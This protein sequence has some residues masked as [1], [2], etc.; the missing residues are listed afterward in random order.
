M[1][2]VQPSI[3]GWVLLNIWGQLKSWYISIYGH[4]ILNEWNFIWAIILIEFDFIL[5]QFHVIYEEF[6]L[7]YVIHPFLF[8]FFWDGWKYLLWLILQLEPLPP[9]H[10]HSLYVGRYHSAYK[11]SG[12]FI[13]LM[14][15]IYMSAFSVDSLG[16]FYM[17][18]TFPLICLLSCLWFSNSSY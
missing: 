18:C 3:Q 1:K 5:V 11:D 16:T 17:S 14:D 13:L 4:T 8:L 6:Y 10:P 12:R 2:L 7:F 15:L 9:K